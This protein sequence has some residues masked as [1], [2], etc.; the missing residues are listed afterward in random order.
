MFFALLG[1]LALSLGPQV[2]LSQS[3][4]GFF[5]LGFAQ[6]DQCQPFAINFRGD[7][8]FN[9][10]PTRLTVLPF[11]SVPVEIPVPESTANSTGLNLNFVPF[12]SQT[13]FIASL[14][15]D[16]NR[17]TTLV[18]DVI[19]VEPSQNNSCLSPSRQST[20]PFTIEGG[21]VSQCEDFTV[22]Y[23][24]PNAPSIRL[25]SP[26]GFSFPLRMTSNSNG[27][28]TYTMTAFR[29]IQVLLLFDDGN[30]ARRTSPLLSVFGSSSSSTQCFPNFSNFGGKTSPS[31][32][33]VSRGVVIGLSVGGGLVILIAV[34]MVLF[35]LRERNTRRRQLESRLAFDTS[36]TANSDPRGRDTIEQKRRISMPLPPLPPMVHNTVTYP[37]GFVKDP[38]YVSEKYSPTISDYPRTSISWEVVDLEAVPRKSY[39]T[40]LSNM[41][42]ERLLNMAAN[43]NNSNE[44]RSLQGAE[45]P[46]S[47]MS[48][49]Q[50]Q[51][52][53]EVNPAIAVT[54]Q[55]TDST[56][57][58]RDISPPDV[59]QNPSFMFFGNDSAYADMHGFSGVNGIE[60]FE[61]PSSMESGLL[62][63]HSDTRESSFEARLSHG[64]RSSNG[65]LD[66][67]ILQQ[68]INAVSVGSGLPTTPRS[69]QWHSPSRQS[70]ILAARQHSITFPS[71]AKNRDSGESWVDRT[72]S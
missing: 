35:V 16:R 57:R 28:A 10:T 25:F 44:V 51:Q 56:I 18:S 8:K 41:D 36:N 20:S 31:S 40:R 46:T 62:R 23:T 17:S 58:P 29:G 22:A 37:E 39:S 21:Q 27:K 49:E 59:P 61:S 45:Y 63:P 32:S 33:G 52:T 30:G 60:L 9:S 43:Q 12:A 3:S 55:T 13:T 70:S 72:R 4:F 66:Y 2:V 5:R 50:Q 34:A 64:S 6:V 47:P 68:P 65:T 11:D 14:D 38:P 7:G 24:T 15:D 71:S 67:P 53:D 48:P 54:S 1:F 69:M 19:K 42:I 26:N